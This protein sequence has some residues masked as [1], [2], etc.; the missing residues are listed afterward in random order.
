MGISTG[1]GKVTLFD[2]FLGAALRGEVAGVAENSGTAAIVVGQ[3]G[4]AAET[5]TGT[6]SGNRAHLS[7][8]LNWKPSNGSVSFEARVKPI[9]DITS[10]A[11]FVG[12]TDSVA[13]EFPIEYA[14]T[15]ITSNASNAVGF[16]F[17][18]AGTVAKWHGL[19]VASDVDAITLT[20]GAIKHDGANQD[21]PVADTYETFRIEVNTDGDAVL[22]YGRDSGARYGLRTVLRIADAVTPTVLLTPMVQVE[23]RTTAAKG[24]YTDYLFCEGGRA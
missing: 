6:S 17:D 8:G 24:A 16:V 2:D 13:Q 20:N 4:G 22:A 1:F 14:T 15:T 9:T 7:A 18:T 11:H 5:T 10:R 3:D 19:A 12:L 21:A 23:T